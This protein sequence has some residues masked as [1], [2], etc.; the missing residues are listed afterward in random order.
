MR[1][2]SY[3]N[4]FK[5]D[6]KRITKRGKD[7]NKLDKVMEIL[8]TGKPLDKKYRDHALVGNLKGTRDLHI[9][10]DWLL[11]YKITDTEVEYVRTG[12]HNDVFSNY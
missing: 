6:I 8:E 1:T 2:P 11:L 10:P 9:E 3:T 5:R 7:L 4:A 12:K